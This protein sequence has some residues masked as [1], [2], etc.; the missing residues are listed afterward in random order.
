MSYRIVHDTKCS[1][2]GPDKNVC[3]CAHDAV[4]SLTN[5]ANLLVDRMVELLHALENSKPNG[6][7]PVMAEA[8]RARL[9]N[10]IL[11]DVNTLTK[12][13]LANWRTQKS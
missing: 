4:L 9:Y 10:D 12:K 13:M 2:Y 1:E 8:V 6:D 3:S 11:S 5:A 7:L